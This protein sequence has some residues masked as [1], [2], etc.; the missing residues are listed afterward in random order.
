LNTI[1]KQHSRKIE[2][3]GLAKRYEDL[4]FY[5]LIAILFNGNFLNFHYIF[6]L[7]LFRNNMKN[8]LDKTIVK[9]TKMYYHKKEYL[10]L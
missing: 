4:R 10:I 2:F 6:L 7:K 1:T 8:W 3:I 5:F 9:M